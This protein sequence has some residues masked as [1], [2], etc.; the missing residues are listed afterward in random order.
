MGAVRTL[1]L[2]G[3]LCAVACAGRPSA[4]SRAAPAGEREA[5][6]P[7]ELRELVDR[8]ANERAIAVADAWLDRHG[9][10][11]RDAARIW[12]L[13]G[14]AL[15]GSGRSL[16][17]QL[18]F[19]KAIAIDP[20]DA[21][22]LFGLGKRALEVDDVAAALRWLELAAEVDPSSGAIHRALA[23]AQTKKGDPE[24]ALVHLRRACWLSPSLS[25]DEALG[26]ALCERERRNEALELVQEIEGRADDGPT[27]LAVARIH[28]ACFDH[29]AADLAY[30]RA[31]Y[32]A[33]ADHQLAREHAAAMRERGDLD[34]ANT[35]LRDQLQ[36]QRD[37]PDVLLD[38][39]RDLAAGG[40]GEGE[41]LAIERA[42]DVAPYD[43]RVAVA[44]VSVLAR[45]GHCTT[46]QAV[47]H[48]LAPQLE[49]DELGASLRDEVGRC[50]TPLAKPQH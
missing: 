43:R 23:D 9:S 32:L 15:L 3:C 4:P 34:A 35:V 46:A 22:A 25:C 47:L 33:P 26:L 31:R 36:V 42:Y 10:A 37:Q 7:K 45:R 38:L 20:N 39:A 30:R 6:A 40:D 2:L 18:S 5:S 17:A 24:A 19:R 41:E 12:A 8:G 13:R 29:E 16:A 44:W 11:G 49:R 14:W 28:A 27:R 48:D 21:A 1:A 50:V